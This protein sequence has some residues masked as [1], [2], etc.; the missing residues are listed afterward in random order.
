MYNIKRKNAK[1]YKNKIVY[2]KKSINIKLPIK[3]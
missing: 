1:L 2:I 3:L